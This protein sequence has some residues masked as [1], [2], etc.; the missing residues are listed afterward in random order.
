MH[1]R[2]HFKKHSSGYNG[3]PT[4]QRTLEKQT[5]WTF[6]KQP[7]CKQTSRTIEKQTPC[8]PECKQYTLCVQVE[9]SRRPVCDTECVVNAILCRARCPAPH[10]VH[11]CASDWL[12]RACS[13]AGQPCDGGCVPPA[14][15]HTSVQSLR[16][17]VRLVAQGL[18][19]SR[20]LGHSLSRGSVL[21]QHRLPM[22]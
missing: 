2:S 22:P 5:P 14:E 20:H 6:E 19:L 1:T 11:L 7:S 18:P 8:T 3:N 15:W 12:V 4:T 9:V 13:R 21:G 17:T 16:R 10:C